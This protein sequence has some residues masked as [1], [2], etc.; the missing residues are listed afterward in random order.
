MLITESHI[1]NIS[2]CN[3]KELLTSFQF[4]KID[5]V[6]IDIEMEDWYYVTG[7]MV[8]SNFILMEA[9]EL[10]SNCSV[11]FKK[12]IIRRHVGFCC[13]TMLFATDST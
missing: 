4:T 3:L 1:G 6:K 13:Q 2:D 12:N 11:A 8:D 5:T 7:Q 9:P 10:T